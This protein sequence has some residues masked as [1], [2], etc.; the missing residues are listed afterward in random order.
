MI[1]KKYKDWNIVSTDRTKSD[2]GVVAAVT[3]ENV[4]KSA[5]MPEICCILAVETHTVHLAL[6]WAKVVSKRKFA[7]FT[8]SRSCLRINQKRKLTTPKVSELTQTIAA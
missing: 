4:T 7:I 3:A 1:E 6:Y 2:M 5:S 8:D